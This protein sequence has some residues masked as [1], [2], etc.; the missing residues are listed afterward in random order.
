[1]DQN[2]RKL[3]QSGTTI[4]FKDAS[5]ELADQNTGALELLVPDLKWNATAIEIIG[6]AN[7]NSVEAGGVSPWVL[8]HQRCLVVKEMLEALGVSVEKVK[9]TQGIAPAEPISNENLQ[10]SNLSAADRV[11]IR[12]SPRL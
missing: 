10:P 7:E 5:V 12:I 3:F 2:D 4:Y 8:A 1:L 6:F 11:E 9:L